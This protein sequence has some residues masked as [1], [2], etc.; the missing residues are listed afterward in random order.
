MCIRDSPKGEEIIKPS[1]LIFSRWF[2]AINTFR[3]S[4][5]ISILLSLSLIHIYAEG[6]IMFRK[7]HLKLTAYMGIILIL[8][9]F[10]VS[11]GIYQFTK[12]VFED[13]NKELM[14]AERCV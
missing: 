3:C 9:M 13:G 14:R 8:F 7:L 10:F 12:M 2:E 1:P 6:E 5:F 4:V 11:A